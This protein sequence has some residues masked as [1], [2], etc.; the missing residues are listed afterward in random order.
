MKKLK[1][2]S[3]GGFITMALGALIFALG[4]IK[5]AVDSKQLEE[6]IEEVVDERL[7]EKL[8]ETEI[9]NKK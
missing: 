3:G 4:I 9:E 6:H 8:G 2:V 7:K 5:D 1:S